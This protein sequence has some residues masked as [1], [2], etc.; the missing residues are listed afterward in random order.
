MD[1]LPIDINMAF[2][3]KIMQQR[4]YIENYEIMKY[5]DYHGTIFQRIFF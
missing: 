4:N 2:K 3:A 1:I 5:T